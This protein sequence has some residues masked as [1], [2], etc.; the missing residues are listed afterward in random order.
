[1]GAV[2]AVAAVYFGGPA[3]LPP[4]PSPAPGGAVA[5]ALTVPRPARVRAVVVDVLGR[6]VAVAYDADVAGRAL[7]EVD[8]ATLAPGTY[9]L[10]VTTGGGAGAQSRP[11]TV[12]R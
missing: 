8:T 1:M 11:F 3:P 4:R 2:V 9:V 12:A 5:F 7:I 10:R 6:E